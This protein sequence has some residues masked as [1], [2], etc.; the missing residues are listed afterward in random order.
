MKTLKYIIAFVFT[1]TFASLFTI[2]EASK[3]NV[4]TGDQLAP[5]VPAVATFKDCLPGS[6]SVCYVLLVNLYPEVPDEADFTEDLYIDKAETIDLAP[7][8][9][10]EATFEDVE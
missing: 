2:S 5:S 1:F 6:E 8:L 7:Q 9:P 3:T 4:T 10:E